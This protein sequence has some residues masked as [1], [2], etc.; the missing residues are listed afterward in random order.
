MKSPHITW[1]SSDDP[2]D[3]F[4]SIDAAIESPDGLLAAG[5]DLSKERLLFAYQQ[6][7]FPWFEDG[8]PILWWSPNPRCVIRPREFHVSRRLRRFF[9]NSTYEIRFNGAFDQVIARCADDRLGQDGTWITE[10][11]K[12]A[13]RG[14]HHAGWAHSVEVY[15]DNQLIGGLY[16]LAIDGCFFGESMFSDATNAS[17]AAMLALCQV[18]AA[19][20]FAVLD[21]QVES[22]HLLSLGA[23][24]MPRE[25]F[26]E[27]L[28]KCCAN[29]TKFENWPV[30]ASRIS[31]FLVESSPAPLQ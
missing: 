25:R 29:A 21:C 19:N 27:T 31:T 3:V 18:I 28:K 22:P 2:P 11:M 7:I 24:L 20:G 4:P 15:L 30:H 13:Y 23:R 5:G 1:I 6:G 16:G 17:K 12:T 10:E 26:A 9:R 14:L 8:Q